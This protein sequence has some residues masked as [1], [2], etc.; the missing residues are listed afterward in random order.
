MKTLVVNR[1]DPPKAQ[2]GKLPTLAGCTVQTQSCLV[3]ESPR[4]P[5]LAVYLK[6]GVPARLA[7]AVFPELKDVATHSRVTSRAAAAGPLR[8]STKA[9]LQRR[10]NSF[11]RLSPWAYRKRR[12]D[13]KWGTYQRANRV[14]SNAIGWVSRTHVTGLT[15]E[16]EQGL[17]RAMDL[18]RP[19][20][21]AFER[22]LPKAYVAQKRMLGD[23]PRLAPALSTCVCNSNFRT[24]LHRDGQVA[25]GSCLAFAVLGDG[26]WRG[27]E[28][29]LPELGLAFD[30]RPRDVVIFDASLWHG[31]APFRG[32]GDRLSCVFYARKP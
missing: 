6:G 5:P 23:W 8:G 19:V 3:R 17:Y 30:L 24:A 25:P 9:M 32:E 20:D 11:E 29:V 22:Y 26:A 7:A 21:I 28:L 14:H 2:K 18:A 1:R 15:L 27:G 31:N 13:G 4:G 10:P 16:H 12:R